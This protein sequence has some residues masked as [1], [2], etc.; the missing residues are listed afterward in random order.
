MSKVKGTVNCV[1]P[2]SNQ[3]YGHRGRKGP[4]PHQQIYWAANHTCSRQAKPA[5]AQSSGVG[6]IASTMGS[7]YHA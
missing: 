7:V 2:M 6:K 4:M 1:Q 3:T 5:L